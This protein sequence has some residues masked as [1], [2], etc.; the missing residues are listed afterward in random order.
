V[1]SRSR[2]SSK[3]LR[4]TVGKFAKKALDSGGHVPILRSS[5]FPFGFSEEKE[6]IMRSTKRG[7]VMAYEV[8]I[9]DIPET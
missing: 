7:Q 3:P 9:R 1:A 6:V 5:F 4:K 8:E 2:E